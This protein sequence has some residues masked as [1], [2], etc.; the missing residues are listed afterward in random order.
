MYKILSLVLF[1]TLLLTACSN[2][3]VKIGDNEVQP[4]D[5]EQAR[6][7]ARDLTLKLQASQFYPLGDEATPHYRQ[8]FTPGEQ[9]A[10]WQQI[11]DRYG[12]FKF[13]TYQQTWV[14][15]DGTN[16][17]VYRFRGVFSGDAEPEIR[18]TMDGDKKLAEYK[19]LDWKDEME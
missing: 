14:S 16:M 13:L 9:A 1:I 7:L 19:V 4:K 5:R 2:R 12:D 17:R 11:H 18:I 8:T 3:F 15:R 10:A 6:D